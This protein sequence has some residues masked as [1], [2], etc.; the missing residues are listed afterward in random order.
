VACIIQCVTH[1]Y[2][3]KHTHVYVALPSQY[4]FYH[5]SWRTSFQKTNTIQLFFSSMMQHRNMSTKKEKIIANF[6]GGKSCGVIFREFRH[7]NVT[8]NW[9]YR[10]VTCWKDTSLRFSRLITSILDVIVCGMQGRWPHSWT[11]PEKP[12]DEYYTMI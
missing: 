5:Y 1:L 12:S 6:K 3:Y 2:W 11:C 9:V 4:F 7:P 10:T 8:R